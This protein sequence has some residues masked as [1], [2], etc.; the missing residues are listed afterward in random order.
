MSKVTGVSEAYLE[1]R[2]TSTM[3]LFLRKGSIADVG[4]GS[5]YTCG[6][7]ATELINC[8]SDRNL[9]SDCKNGGYYIDILEVTDRKQKRTVLFQLIGEKCQ[10]IFRTFLDT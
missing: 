9:S 10:E 8:I 2:R 7:R 3:E 1:P 6:F 5:K 4:L